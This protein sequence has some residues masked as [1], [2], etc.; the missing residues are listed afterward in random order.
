M[1][2][3]EELAAKDLELK[4]LFMKQQLNELIDMLNGMS[5]EDVL[6]LTN[7]NWDVVKKYFD[8][9]RTDLLRQHLR[10]VAFGSFMTEYAGQRKLYEE[11]DYAV[12]FNMFEEIFSLLHNE[13]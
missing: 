5:D 12:K 3:R 6:E 7:I 2:L 1:E 8:M 11:A 4:E 9:Q 13:Q 10:F